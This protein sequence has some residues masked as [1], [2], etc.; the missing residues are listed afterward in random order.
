M[1]M[2]HKITALCM[3]AALS[4]SLGACSSAPSSQANSQ[5]SSEA[6]GGAEPVTLKMAMW[7]ST[8]SF[9]WQMWADAYMEQHP[10]VTI[11]LTDLGSSDYTTNLM[12]QLAGGSDAFDLI[13]VK[14]TPGYV[15]MSTLGLLEPLN[16]YVEQYPEEFEPLQEMLDRYTLEDGNF[17]QIPLLKNFW[18]LFYNKDLFDQ[19]GVEYPTNDMTFDEM[20]ELARRVTY[21]EGNDK[22]YG[23]HYHTW[24]SCVQTY[25][26]LDGKNS[27]ID[28]N[29]DWLIPY[30][31][32]VL[33]QQK[34]GICMDYATLKTSGTHYSGVF[35]NNNVA[36]MPQG[37]WF[38]SM[39]LAK[40]K[41]GE[42]LATNWGM[43]KMPHPEGVEAGTTAFTGAAMA[44]SS[45]SKHK[46][47][48]F[49]FLRFAISE[50]GRAI[51]TSI[52][53]FP[54]V[55]TEQDVAELVEMEGFP[56]DENSKEALKTGT[57]YLEM[58]VC[59]QTADIETIL[60]QCHDNIM[61]ENISIEDGIAEMNSQVQALLAG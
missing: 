47:I 48:A 26:A 10:E 51:A 52:G 24:R 56:Q 35:F 4:L 57:L 2:M 13:A 21:G 50:E 33:Q 11:E 25:G 61:T 36:M 53:Q 20:D 28:G 3:T 60:N 19:A 49:D 1:K 17:Y 16:S 45:Q 9:H 39:Q 38:I 58:P 32:T 8:T 18:L 12:T 55:M 37:S 41:S 22:V 43:A 27:L 54:S 59:T 15:N 42:S 7:D 23:V 14:D 40:V 29:Y 30:Y 6:A 34:D 5:T 31:E 46:D 44:V